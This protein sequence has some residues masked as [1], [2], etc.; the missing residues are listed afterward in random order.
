MPR[1]LCLLVMSH[2]VFHEFAKSY[3]NS[4]RISLCETEALPLKQTHP[5]SSE[6]LHVEA[7]LIISQ[8][9]LLLSCEWQGGLLT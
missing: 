1:H 7:P 9:I 6:A 2:L 4:H 5:C 3:V 8:Q